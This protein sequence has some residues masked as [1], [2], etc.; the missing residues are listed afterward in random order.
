VAGTA[1][2]LL[3]LIEVVRGAWWCVRVIQ[4]APQFMCCMSFPS[5][6]H[7]PPRPLTHVTSTVF[8]G[9][10]PSHM[11]TKWGVPLNVTLGAG[12]PAGSNCARA[13]TVACGAMPSS[14]AAPSTLPPAYACS[15]SCLPHPLHTGAHTHPNR[16]AQG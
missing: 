12:A 15:T 16:H 10:L 7:C 3:A 14:P 2:L 4:A 8:Y 11:V 9:W 1:N 5:P 6:R 13:L